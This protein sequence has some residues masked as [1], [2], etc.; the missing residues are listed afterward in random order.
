MNSIRDLNMGTTEIQRGIPSQNASSRFIGMRT[1]LSAFSRV[2]EAARTR[3]S[4]LLCILAALVCISAFSAPGRADYTNFTIIPERNIFNTKRSPAYTPRNKP[5][6]TSRNEYV[7]LTGTMHDEKGS[8]AFF[9]GS[10]SD[11]RKV[12]KPK[13]DIAGFQIEDIEH[14]YVKLKRGTNEM[15]LP[16]N[17][18]LA[19]EEQGEWQLADRAPDRPTEVAQSSSASSDSSSRRDDRGDRRD[20][21]DRNGT[22]G[23]AGNSGSAPGNAAPNLPGQPVASN[24]ANSSNPPAAN[25]G[26]PQ[27]EADVLRMLEERRRQEDQ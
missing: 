13:D 14:A 17:K 23:S 19:R 26:A 21:R 16:V 24:T 11:Y 15:I 9:D 6:R 22:S 7:A 12:L 5:V 25:A 3:L 10:Q 20:R 8:L 1:A 4:A 27:T 18:E 2:I